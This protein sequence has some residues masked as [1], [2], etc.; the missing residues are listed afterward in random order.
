MYVY[1]NVWHAALQLC[2]KVKFGSLVIILCMVL[3][4]L[5]AIL[6]TIILKVKLFILSKMVQEWELFLM[7]LASAQQQG[8]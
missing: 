7:L 3:M 4:E 2:K 1:P 5:L 6:T 8:H